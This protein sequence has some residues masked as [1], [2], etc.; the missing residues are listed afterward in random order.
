MARP[1]EGGGGRTVTLAEVVDFYRE[2]LGREP[3]I[4]TEALPRVGNSYLGT[5]TQIRCSQ[6]AASYRANH[7]AEPDL[8]CYNKDLTTGATL[9]DVPTPPTPTPVPRPPTQIP[10]GDLPVIG[11]VIT[12]LWPPIQEILERVNAIAKAVGDDI[13]EV[14]RPIL[15]EVISTGG[16]IT[17]TLADNLTQLLPAALSLAAE[18]ADRAADVA[19]SFIENAANV[20][21]LFTAASDRLKVEKDGLWQFISGALG[22]GFGAGISLLLGD[23]EDTHTRNLNPILD[24]IQ[25][26]D[27]VPRWVKDALGLKAGVTNPLA[28]IVGISLLMSVAGQFAAA[29]LGPEVANTTYK[30]NEDRTVLLVSAQQ[31]ATAAVQEWRDRSALANIAQR[32]GY[33]ADQFGVLTDLARQF[34]QVQ[35]VTGAALRGAINGEQ[36]TRLLTRL[37]YDDE[38]RNVVRAMALQL[39]GVQD[40]IRMAVR[41]VFNPAQRSALTLD[42]E[43]PTDLTGHARAIGLSEQWARNFWAAHWELPS[44]NQVFD[45]LHRGEVTIQEVDDFLKAADYAPIWRARLRAISYNVFTRVDIRRI[46]DLRDKDHAWLVA[47]HKRLGYNDADSEE[48]SAFVEVLNDDERGAKRKELSA[49]LVSRIISGVVGGTIEGEQATQMFSRLG[50]G[51]DSIATF[52]TEA[53]LI[54]NEQRTEKVGNLLGDLYVKGYRSRLEVVEQLRERNFTQGEIDERLREWDLEK[55]LRAP[56]EREQKDR[57]LTRADVE[58]MYRARQLPREQAAF[59]LQELRYDPPEIKAILDLADFREKVNEDKDRVEVVHRKFVKGAIDKVSAQQQLGQIGLR[60]TQIEASLA[61]WELEISAKTADLSVGQV[62]ELYKGHHW[63]DNK[64]RD[65]LQRI[66]YDED[67]SRALL[68]LWGSKIEEQLRRDEIAAQKAEDARLREAERVIRVAAG[69]EKDLAK[70]DLLN[71]GANGVLRWDEVKLELTK[72]GYSEYEAGVLIRTK[73]AQGGKTNA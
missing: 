61:R 63:D 32:N 17:Q 10:G 26:T 7:G 2:Y 49:S 42:S 29:I 40:T 73:Q 54:R 53:A 65:Y 18:A 30:N 19:A 66:G 51:A 34:P 67:E 6:E 28:L 3:N 5:M 16:R 41:E 72:R 71:A 33:N 12:A 44:V 43:Y 55:E 1:D 60:A 70:T 31:A 8:W 45:M 46:H 14:L 50:Y 20:D 57:D 64:T 48:L 35:T 52:L 13:G 11:G 36:E 69:K 62:G 24:A 21:D 25:N 56:T 27:T 22:D 37:G 38:S 15:E 68:A 9:P 58:A 39:P 23:L 47:Q 59:M 4:A